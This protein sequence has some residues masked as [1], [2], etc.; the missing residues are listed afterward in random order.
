LKDHQQSFIPRKKKE[1]DH[2]SELSQ[3]PNHDEEEETEQIPVFFYQE[4]F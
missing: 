1:K 2:S 4:N 3:S